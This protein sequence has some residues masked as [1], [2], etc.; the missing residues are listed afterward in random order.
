MDQERPEPLIRAVS[1]VASTGLTQL[2]AGCVVVRWLNDLGSFQ[3][4]A[5]KKKCLDEEEAWVMLKVT[6]IESGSSQSCM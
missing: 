3:K 1:I 2:L 6:V 5:Q 4:S